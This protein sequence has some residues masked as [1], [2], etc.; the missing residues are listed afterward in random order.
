LQS[1]SDCPFFL[2]NKPSIASGRGEILEPI[3]IT[4]SG[5]QL[6]LVNPGIHINT[7]SVFKQIQP[8]IPSKK[9][10]E[11]ILQPVTSWKKDL[12]NDFE[13][14]VFPPYPEIKKLK[15]KLYDMGA[16]YASMTGTGSTVYGLFN[17]GH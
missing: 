13:K 2:I 3:D 6:L 17:K 9:I 11:I 12:K 1:G 7:G 4:L 15:E 8:A 16:V 10:S 14:I 5:Y